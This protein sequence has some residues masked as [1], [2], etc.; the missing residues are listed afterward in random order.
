MSEQKIRTQFEHWVQRHGFEITSH[1]GRYSRPVVRWMWEAWR[2]QSEQIT[3]LIE[4]NIRL[5]NQ[6]ADCARLRKQCHEIDARRDAHQRHAAVL[7]EEVEALR[8]KLHATTQEALRAEKE[9]D[10]L[11]AA[12]KSAFEKLRNCDYV[13]AR[14][15]LVLAMSN[16]ENGD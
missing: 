16:V 4:Q 5:M 7:A 10:E 11:M 1:L 15:D 8:A 9:R 6:A 12:T 2:H 14:A 13:A 3:G